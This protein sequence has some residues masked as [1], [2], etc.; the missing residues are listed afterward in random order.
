MAVI[1][2][3]P[4]TRVIPGLALVAVLVAAAG[5]W[6]GRVTLGSPAGRPA[7]QTEPVVATVS[8]QTVGRSLSLTVTVRQPFVAAAV[9][10]LAGT[11]TTLNTASPAKN[12]D[13]LYAVNTVPVRAVA[14]ELPFYRPLGAGANGEDV[15]Q[16]Q[17]ALA[18][19]GLFKGSVTSSYGASTADAVKAWQRNL[20]IPVTGVVG[21]GEI[22]AVPKLPATLR[23]GEMIVRGARVTGGEQAVFAPSGEVHF[24]LVIS[25]AQ[26]AG[27]PADATVVVQHQNYSWPAVITDVVSGTNDSVRMTL[28]APAGGPVC[29]NDCAALPA[30]EQASLRGKITVVPE[31]SGPTVPV[32][33]LHTEADGKAFVVLADGTR[34]DVTVRASAGGLAVVGGLSAGERVQVLSTPGQQ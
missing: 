32:A 23:L 27:I 8:E 31:V 15:A 17:R 4:L 13:V 18:D 10:G 11:V 19:M 9:N 22:V 12:G 28:T 7:E 21:Y 29:G 14:G 26:R 1:V 16:L 6:A 30:A 33:A 3:Q 20:K 2:R 5:W 25:Q 34:R 24:E